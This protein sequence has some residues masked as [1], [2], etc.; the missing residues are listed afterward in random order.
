MV[1]GRLASDV[2]AWLSGYAEHWA[3]HRIHQEEARLAL[4]DETVQVRYQGVAGDMPGWKQRLMGV[5]PTTVVLL[6]GWSRIRGIGLELDLMSAVGAE[7]MDS[8]P[9]PFVGVTD[10]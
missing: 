4:E 9:F 3:E 8:E 7:I 5:R 2:R 10:G 6:P 1:I